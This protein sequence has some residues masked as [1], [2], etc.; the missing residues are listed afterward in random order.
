MTLKRSTLPVSL[1]CACSLFTSVLSAQTTEITSKE[2]PITFKSG[3]NLVPV[4]VVV[5][6]GR[7]HAVGN[8]GR[9]DFQLFDN[10]K[11]QM[12]SKFTVEKLVNDTVPAPAAPAAA[13][14]NNKPPV[15]G[16]TLV[17]ATTDG[18]PD[19]FVAYLF[20]DL[21]MTFA[22]LVHTRDAAWRQINSS[23]HA[24]ERA[25]VYTTSGQT[26]Q[27]FTSDKEKLHQALLTID[28]GRA[29]ASKTIEQTGCPPMTYY[30]GDLII[31]KNDQTALTI[32][33]ADTMVCANLTPQ[34]AS[35][36]ASM[37]HAAAVQSVGDGDR[38]TAAS[39]D[40]LRAIVARMAAMPG[41]RNI[42]LV[43]TGFLVLE[44]RHDEQTR[45]I[46]RAIRANVVIGALDARGLYSNVTIPDASQGHVNPATISMKS[47]YVTAEAMAV[48]DVMAG[49]ADGTGGTF[50]HGTNDFDEGIARTAAAPEYLYVLGYSPLDLKLDGKFHN[51]KVTLN[52]VRGMELQVRKGYYAPKY[53]ANPADQAKQQV[54]EAFFSR[55]QVHDLP[56]VLQTQYFKT[57]NGDAT[58]SAV[59]KVDVKKLAFRKEGGRNFDNVTVVTGVFDN[60]GNYVTGIEKTV[61][62]KLFDETLEKRLGAGIAVKNSFTV[63]PGRYVVRMVVRDSEGQLMSEQSSLVEIP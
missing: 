15:S 3:V 20:D 28:T 60:D 17:D 25:A 56:A 6:D 12:I 31:N 19:R 1:L 38:Y 29:S 47:P 32:A 53:A 22:D 63:H 26:M 7:G 54:A 2:A 48:S 16:E 36:A 4:P 46:E 24:L 59:A 58:L 9:D 43:S 45:L 11:V 5:R 8:L 14:S 13:P 33:I 21:H 44:D 10:G 37:A 35:M 61:E 50:Y 18:I 42:V 40:M 62:L 49:V 27:E 34:Q 57:D 23:T 55:D 51:L 52:G 41:Q 30:M 39:L